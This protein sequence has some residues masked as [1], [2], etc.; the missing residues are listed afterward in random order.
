MIDFENILCKLDQM[1][2]L[3]YA[4]EGEMI[5]VD[6][7]GSDMK[8]LHNLVYILW[9]QLQQVNKD[10]EKLRGGPKDRNAIYQVSY[11]EELER[12]I[13]ELINK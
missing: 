12:E 9:E 1:D 10:V 8:H 7:A 11:V 4:I 3:M 6:E 2:S 5:A 13:T